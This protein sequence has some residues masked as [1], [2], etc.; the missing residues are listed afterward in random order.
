[1]EQFFARLLSYMP[2]SSLGRRPSRGTSAHVSARNAKQ[3]ELTEKRGWVFFVFFFEA[4][5]KI[6]AAQ[7]AV[8]LTSVFRFSF[9]DIVSVL[10]REK[11]YA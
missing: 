3:K 10:G 7:R 6:A 9:L 11:S 8:S 4:S 1:M 2:L 5:S